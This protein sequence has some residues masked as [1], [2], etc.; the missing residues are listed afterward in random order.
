MR[1]LRVITS[2]A[3]IEEFD[4]PEVFEFSRVTEL[5]DFLASAPRTGWVDEGGSLAPA[6][7]RF[8]V[9]DECG[10]NITADAVELG[11]MDQSE[12]R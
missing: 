12:V 8:T 11:W 9:Y 1:T 7:V 10:K 5:R 6:A 2:A 3:L 4:A